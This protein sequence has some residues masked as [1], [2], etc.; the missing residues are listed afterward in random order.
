M[1]F[2]DTE[3]T[4]LIRNAALHLDKQPHVIEIGMVRD[5]EIPDR[6]TQF[7]VVLKVPVKLEPI[8]T[9]ITGL[10]DEDLLDAPRFEDVYEDLANFVRGETQLVAHNMPFDYEMLM[11]ELRRIGKSQEFPMPMERIDTVQMAKPF[12]RGQ[13][14]KL[15]FLYEDLVGPYQQTH[16]A[17]DDALMLQKVYN[18]LMVK[19]S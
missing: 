18:A 7:G 5:P 4:G 14:K 3:T 9:K 12:Y 6:P 1:L 17:V 11:F 8:I 13:F 2:F 19:G 15:I 16:R 10:R